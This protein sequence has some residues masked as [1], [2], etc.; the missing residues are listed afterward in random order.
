[1]SGLDEFDGLLRWPELS[2]WIASSPLPGSG[3]PISV[4]KLAGGS[5]NNLFLIERKGGAFVLRRPPQHLRPNSNDTMMREARV[6]GAL[7]GSSVPHPHIYAACA[8]EN[9]IGACFYAME[10][11]DGFSPLAGLPAQYGPAWRRAMAFSLV[12]GAAQLASIDPISVG[13]EGFGKTD[14]W[15][16]RQVKRWHSQLESYREMPGYPGGLL[17]GVDAVGAWL[18]ANRP[19]DARIGII[20]GDLQWANVMFAHDAPR[21]A[22]MIDWELS[23]LGDPLLDLGWILTSWVDDDDPPGHSAQVTPHDSFPTRAELV[24]RYCA[25]TGRDPSL[26]PWYFVL[27]CYKL[28]IILEGTHARALA[29]KAS[30]T[31]GDA[32]HGYADWLFRKALQLIGEQA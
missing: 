10:S 8:D 7:A 32:L 16:E 18:E 13:L 15:L 19:A 20:H 14:N 27:A 1:M 23:T 29:G 6:L 3:A 5:Q 24:D 12:D 30:A 22:A 2:D 28:G 17:P 26:V 21:L 9:I 11:I 4:R 25:A 31:I